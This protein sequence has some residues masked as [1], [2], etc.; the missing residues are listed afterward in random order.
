MKNKFLKKFTALLLGT[1]MV[2]SLI[3]ATL[4]TVNAADVTGNK[5]TTLDELT[6]GKYFIVSTKGYILQNYD[7]KWVLVSEIESGDSVSTDSAYL[8]SVEVNGTNVTLTDSKGQQIAPSSK[9]DNGIKV[10]THSWSVSFS[11]GSFKFAGGGDY[12]VTLA[13][14]AGSGEKVRAYKNTTVTGNQASSYTTTFYLYKFEESAGGDEPAC[15][16]ANTTAIGTPSEATC[17]EPGIT[18]G[19]MCLD[20]GATLE[21]Q[22]TISAKGHT[23]VNGVCSVC[24][25]KFSGY[26][27]VTDASTLQVGDKIIIV[28]AGYNFALSTNQK[29]SNRG[30]VEITKSGD[31]VVSPASDVQIITLEAGTKDGTF[32]FN[33]GTGY[34]YAASSNSNHLKTQTTNDANGSWEI[35]IDDANNASIIAQ[36]TYTRN[37]LRYNSSSSLFSCYG[38][39]QQDV[40]IY[41]LVGAAELK[42][43]GL[44][45]NKGITVKVKLD[46]SAEWFAANPD[47]K[48]VFSNGTECVVTGAGEQIFTTTLTPD[49]INK[50]L[51]VTYGDLNKVVSVEKYIELAENKESGNTILHALL[52]AIVNYGKATDGEIT[53]TETFDGVADIETTGDKTI[54]EVGATLGETASIIFNFA[55]AAKAYTFSIANTEGNL[56][57]GTVSGG[58]LEI[59]NI[60]PSNYNDEYTLTVKD[61]ETTV[62]T[63]TF[64]FNAYL[65]ALYN[66]TDN[67]ATKSLVAAV[68]QYGLATEA[69][70][71]TLA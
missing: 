21:A 64:T 2:L 33:V 11:N 56:A 9:T 13:C 57:N 18:A 35:I 40:Y 60:F 47:A 50:E 20:C 28:A 68:Y 71:D 22:E 59:E 69:H 16:H 67:S 4:F 54:F 12:E 55:D 61:G 38:S 37:A 32:A 29:S 65:K 1:I 14:N 5:V 27:L 7:N 53:L 58:K 46:I 24:G 3:P 51:T 42:T 36:G 49:W 15:E 23:L 41:K 48:V 30:Q 19:K 39:G 43:L 63:V 62:A 26:V 25:T 31:T 45:L 70:L 8:W 6:T 34:L 66:S 10:G 17:T 52:A 44:T